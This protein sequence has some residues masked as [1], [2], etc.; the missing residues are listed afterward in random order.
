MRIK[1]VVETTVHNVGGEDPEDSWSRDSTE[2][3]VDNVYAIETEEES[4]ESYYDDPIKDI[5]VDYGDSVY[6][7]V[8]DYESGDTFGRDGGY[9]QVIDVFDNSE[10]ADALLAL[11]RAYD[12]GKSSVLEYKGK[13]YYASWKGYF[14]YTQSIDIWECSVR[15]S[16]GQQNGLSSY[17]QGK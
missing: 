13:Q 8:V 14:E 7:V 1:I 15:H 5:D 3:H 16:A 17:R 2:G 4:R 10:D 6:A 9:Y 12:T 11:A